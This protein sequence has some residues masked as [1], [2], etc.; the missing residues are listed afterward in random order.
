[1]EKT[2]GGPDGHGSSPSRRGE[3]GPEP[4]KFF[5]LGKTQR[6]FKSPPKPLLM[7]HGNGNAS[8]PVYLSRIVEDLRLGGNETLFKTPHQEK[9]ILAEDLS[10][11]ALQT[12]FYCA[13]C[14][15][16]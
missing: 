13:P 16:K 11:E 12:R 4:S 5:S 14:L 10:D 7:N 8:D 15:W 2:V 1:M 3:G 9:K 6:V